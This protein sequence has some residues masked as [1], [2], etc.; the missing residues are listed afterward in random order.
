[1]RKMIVA[2]ALALCSANVASAD[3]SLPLEIK[4]SLTQGA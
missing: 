3:E 4:G 2:A 1:M